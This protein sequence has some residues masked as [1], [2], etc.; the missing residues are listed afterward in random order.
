L[1]SRPAMPLVLL[2]SLWMLR[3][4]WTVVEVETMV[5]AL[6]FMLL[7]LLLLRETNV[8]PSPAGVGIDCLTSASEHADDGDSG[9]MD[10]GETGEAE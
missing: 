9:G 4:L 1:L 2:L 3:P 7:L 8:D 5:V 10:E 6:P